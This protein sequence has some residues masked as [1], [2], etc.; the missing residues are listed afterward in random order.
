MIGHVMKLAKDIDQF[1]YEYDTYDY[2][3]SMSLRMN[4]IIHYDTFVTEYTTKSFEAA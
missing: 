3:D 2:W 4:I 1:A